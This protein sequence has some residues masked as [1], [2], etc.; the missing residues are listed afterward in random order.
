MRVILKF[1]FI[2]LAGLLLLNPTLIKAQSV[3]VDLGNQKQIIRGYG[4]IHINSWTGQQINADMME[5]AFDN[6]P[7]EMG[8]TIFRMPI[9]PSPASWGN[10][11]SVAQYAISKGAIVF[12]SPWNPPSNMRQVLTQTTSGTD[13]VLL[14]EYYDDYVTHLNDYVKFMEDKGVPL[15][16]ISVQNEPDWHGWTTWTPQQMLT[17]VKE[18]AQNINCR[19]IAPESYSF[20]RKMIDPLLKDSIANSH[21]DIVGTHLYGTPKSNFYYPLAFEKGKEIWMT[22]HLFGSDSPEL[23]TWSL[24][25]EVAEEINNCMDAGMS[26]FVYWY[27]RRFYGL[28]NDEGNITD[29]GY[30]MSHFSKFIK[31]GSYRIAT[32]LSSISRVS[33]TAYTS[34]STFV[35]V[36]VNNNTQPVT[37]NLSLQ[38]DVMGIDSLTKFTTTDIKKVVNDGT[39]A[40]ENSNVTITV[41]ARSI[42]T[43]TT[44]PSHGG[45]CDNQ[46][47][48]ATGGGDQKVL[49]QMASGVKVSLKGSLSSDP[50]GE[51]VKY[52]WARN[53]VQV[54]TEPDIDIDL[55][56]GEYT[57]ILSVTDNDGAT[58]TDT[59]FVSVY[60]LN[61]EEVW[62][63]AECTEISSNWKVSSAANCSNGKSIGV[64]AGVQSLNEPSADAADH[65]TYRFHLDETGN[66]KIWAR[67]LVPTANDDSYWVKVDDGS[68]IN[69]NGIKGGNTWQWD[70]VHNQ[71]NESPMIYQLDTGYHTLYVCYRED[72][73]SLDKFYITNN[74]SIPADMGDEA[75]NC[76]EENNTGTIIFSNN[77]RIKISPNPVINNFIIE[78]SEPF[79]SLSIYDINGKE[80]FGKVYGQV[81]CTDDIH[82]NLKRGM[83]IINLNGNKYSES[84]KIMVE[85]QQ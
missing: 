1:P 3:S 81:I 70:D 29:K 17:F 21:F 74:G 44:D 6:D 82:I 13:Y 64:I 4:G 24:A 49:D 12:A 32:T 60:N 28:I 52:S 35:V 8:L 78:S 2:F 30:V 47:P 76:K 63:E 56:V 43:F 62:L 46:A 26:A 15:Y 48:V 9:D 71:S 38:N 11:L 10:E 39:V 33:A 34:D 7:G 59:M 20:Q 53:G 23:N 67:A 68:W 66:Y 16:A 72:G 42:S 37:L 57:F 22:E 14:P 79:Y 51:I 55:N 75:S 58:D 25:L 41:E 40:V 61:N 73:A 85:D 77:N 50:D 45:K 80:V 31:P 5:K 54:S 19:V 69:W 83:Y 27:I 36:V 18:N 84:I 65:L